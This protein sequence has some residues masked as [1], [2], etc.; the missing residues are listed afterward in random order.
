MVQG[1]EACPKCRNDSVITFFHWERG[2]LSRIFIDSQLV[3]LHQEL[4]A[5]FLVLPDHILIMVTE[6]ERST[7]NGCGPFQWWPRRKD[8]QGCSFCPVPACPYLA[9]KS[10][11]SLALK[12]TSGISAYTED[13]LLRHPALCLW[14][15]QFLDSW[16]FHS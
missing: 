7:L 3:S 1:Q 10:I 14:G 15:E 4:R 6:V 8:A 12:P 9:S 11:P 5:D 2:L 16:T 13:L